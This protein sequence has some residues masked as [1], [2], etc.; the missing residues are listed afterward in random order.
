MD[1]SMDQGM[2]RF[3]DVNSVNQNMDNKQGSKRYVALPRKTLEEVLQ[4]VSLPAE[5]LEIRAYEEHETSPVHEEIWEASREIHTQ[6]V[7]I[8]NL[9]Y[10][11]K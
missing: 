3:Y 2:F 5:V 8:K 4:A 6:I 7:K 1:P 9:L 10:S 11:M